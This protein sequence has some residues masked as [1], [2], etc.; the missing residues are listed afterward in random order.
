M[1]DHPH[2]PRSCR[3]FALALILGLAGAARGEEPAIVV[4]Q[5]APRIVRRVY[6]PLNPPAEM[7]KKL[8]LPEAGL[9]EFDF[10]CKILT[11]TDHTRFGLQSVEATVTSVR[12][13][14]HL[15]VTIWT[16][17][18]SN[19]KLRAHEEGH[20][21]IC[22]D[23]YRRAREVA[24]AL[25][26]RALGTKLTS[27][28]HNGGAAIPELR[29]ALQR[30]LAAEFLRETAERCVV[31]QEIYDTITAHGGNPISEA[32]AVAQAVAAEQ[33]RPRD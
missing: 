28:R 19:A 5:T 20:R 6:D 14:T 9:C 32:D 10:G 31:A 26:R 29:E 33:A 13:V 7:L 27:T 8:K 1:P 11:A 12:L 16:V 24:V 22:E 23:Y 3:W 4:E 30:K 2:S 18:E 25:A 17:I 15:D 21:E